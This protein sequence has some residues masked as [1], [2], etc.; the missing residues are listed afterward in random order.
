MSRIIQCFAA[1]V[2][3]NQKWISPPPLNGYLNE[4]RFYAQENI[5][6]KM[7]Y[8]HTVTLMELNEYWENFVICIYCIYINK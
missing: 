5:G 3:K 1:I 4:I 7:F 8:Q 6:G 2:G